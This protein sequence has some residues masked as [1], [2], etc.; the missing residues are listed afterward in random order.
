MCH[1]TEVLKYKLKWFSC[2]EKKIKKTFSQ[3]KVMNN[4]SIHL[5]N[6]QDY[7]EYHNTLH[8]KHNILQPNVKL[9]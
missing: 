7:S 5:I 3:E 9:Q 6:Y 1:L 4:F 2:N 8:D